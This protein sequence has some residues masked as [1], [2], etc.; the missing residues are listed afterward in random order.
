MKKRL[1][2]D[3]N[4]VYRFMEA[5]YGGRNPY[6]NFIERNMAYLEHVIETGEWPALRR[7]PPCFTV[8]QRPLAATNLL[9]NQR[10]MRLREQS[11][12]LNIERPA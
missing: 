1:D 5:L 12:D 9:V 10:I 8:E 11:A 2:G 4:R 6:L 3:F 7:T